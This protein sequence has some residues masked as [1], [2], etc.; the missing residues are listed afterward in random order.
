MLSISSDGG[1][2][3]RENEWMEEKKRR[4]EQE[5]QGAVREREGEHRWTYRYKPYIQYNIFRER[6]RER[7][8]D[9]IQP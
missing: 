5:D 9:R 1:R 6:G 8:T 2:E 7:E 4:V 3:G